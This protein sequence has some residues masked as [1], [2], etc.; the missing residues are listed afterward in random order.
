M[1]TIIHNRTLYLETIY[2]GTTKSIVEKDMHKYAIESKVRLSIGD[3]VRIQNRELV[4]MTSI[5]RMDKGILTYEYHLMPESGIRQKR[6][7]IPN[8]TGISI[9]GKVLEVQKD[10]VRLHLSIDKEQKKEEAFWFPFATPYAA[11]GNSGFYIA[12]EV[13]DTMQLAFSNHQEESAVAQRSIRKGGASNPKVADSSTR[14]LGNANGKEVKLDSQSVTLTASEG[15][16]FLKVDEGQGIEVHSNQP[17][18]VNANQDL[19]LNSKR[20]TLSA[21][22]SIFM[23]CQSSSIV[24]DGITDIQGNLVE[25][26]GINKSP[27]STSNED[28]NDNTDT[29][30]LA[31]DLDG[32]IPSG[33]GVDV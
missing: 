6:M 28:S 12:P 27:V 7:F 2:A 16:V 4:I 11:E 29:L 21:T 15:A 18:Q 23:M 3:R 17:L 25:M 19:I 8:L 20:I 26:E 14:Y 31:L 13:G 32:M 1:L 5:A 30:Q 10:R 24:L 22:E 33:G 9:E